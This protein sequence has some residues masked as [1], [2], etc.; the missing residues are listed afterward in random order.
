MSTPFLFDRPALRKRLMRAS[1]G[2]P[3]RVLHA[4]ATQD[5]LDR[6]SVILRRFDRALMTGPDD[7]CFLAHLIARDQVGEAI[8]MPWFLSEQSDTTACVPKLRQSLVVGDEEIL[9][10]APESFDLIIS[11]LSLQ[12]VN[13][14]PGA[15][16][17]I[18]RAL[19]PDGLFMACLFG[20]ETLRELRSVLT[21]AESE[22]TGGASPRVHPFADLRAVG[23]LLQRAGL[24]LPVI[25]GETLHLRYDHFFALIA[26]LRGM[27]LTNVLAERKRGPLPQAI[28]ARAAALYAERFAD[29]DGRIRATFEII[30]LSGWAPHESQQKPLRPGSAKTRLADALKAIAPPDAPSSS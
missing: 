12:G 4:R 27:G 15:F 17:Q 9:P 7:T 19:R 25:D 14:L 28:L 5:M 23:G 21:Q 18:R 22:V 10:F 29:P 20:G 30:W 16:I 1:R 13:D 11:L 3:V 8:A 24:A 26:D 2:A 6:L